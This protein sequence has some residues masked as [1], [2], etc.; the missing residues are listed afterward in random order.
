MPSTADVLLLAAG[1]VTWQARVLAC[2]H[3][4]GTT[5]ADSSDI[6]QRLADEVRLL[7]PELL[8]ASGAY[9]AA[10]NRYRR[11]REMFAGSVN[12]DVEVSQDRLAKKAI[13]DCNWY[14]SERGGVGPPTPAPLTALDPGRQSPAAGPPAGTGA[15]HPPG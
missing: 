13:A 3:A 6:R 2:E 8:E 11:R 12:Q 10:K 14:G 15:A 1:Q 5:M 9:R 7:L 4:K